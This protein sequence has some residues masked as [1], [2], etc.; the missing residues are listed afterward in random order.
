METKELNRLA[1]VRRR[2]DAIVELLQ[3]FPEALDELNR[4]D[5]EPVE[6]HS[7]QSPEL[8]CDLPLGDQVRILQQQYCDLMDAVAENELAV[9]TQG[10]QIKQLQDQLAKLRTHLRATRKKAFSTD[11]W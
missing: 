1:E 3:M 11:L 8:V 10:K 7:A 9:V 4:G 2:L 5:E 6:P